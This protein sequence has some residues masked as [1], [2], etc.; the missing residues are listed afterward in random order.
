VSV[1]REDVMKI[2]DVE[3]KAKLEEY[4]DERRTG[5]ADYRRPVL[6]V[7]AENPQVPGRP[8]EPFGYTQAEAKALVEAGADKIGVNQREPLGKNIR[9]YT[10]TG[11]VTTRQPSHALPVVERLRRSAVRLGDE[12]LAD[13]IESLK[14]EQRRRRR[15]N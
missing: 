10:N 7:R 6:H 13:L 2:P 5:E 8:I 11:G 3:V 4:M 14:Q 1:R 9:R 15:S 12:D